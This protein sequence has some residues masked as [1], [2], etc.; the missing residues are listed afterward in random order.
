MGRPK[1]SWDVPTQL[2]WGTQNGTETPEK[3]SSREW[4]K[5]DLTTCKVGIGILGLGG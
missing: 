3:F 4:E 2:M 1:L 5:G